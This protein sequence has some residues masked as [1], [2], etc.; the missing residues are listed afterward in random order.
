MISVTPGETAAAVVMADAEP[1][2][3]EAAAEFGTEAPVV[4]EPLA[5]TGAGAEP[6]VDPGVEDVLEAGRATELDEDAAV[7]PAA[8]PVVEE[9]PA[10]SK[11]A[12]IISAGTKRMVAGRF[13]AFPFRFLDQGRR[14]GERWMVRDGFRVWLMVKVI[15]YPSTFVAELVG[16]Q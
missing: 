6:A 5:G 4:M 1:D 15:R 7:L 14:V 3:S 16:C 13:I 9:Q 12:L 2:P 10:T 11:P 8:D